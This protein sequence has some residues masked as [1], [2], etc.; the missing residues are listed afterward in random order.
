MAHGSRAMPAPLMTMLV[1]MLTSDLLH[2]FIVLCAGDGAADLPG[3]SGQV[4]AAAGR[5]AGVGPLGAAGCHRG[6]PRHVQPAH[7]GLGH[8]QIMLTPVSA[9]LASNCPLGWLP[10]AAAA[11]H[12]KGASDSVQ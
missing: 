3:P 12:G 8:T 2:N 6:A 11:M 9:W 1:H 5:A 4:V 7:C 10:Y